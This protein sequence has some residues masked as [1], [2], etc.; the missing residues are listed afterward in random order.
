M[1]D[2]NA[3][4]QKLSALTATDDMFGEGARVISQG[5]VPSTMSA[6]LKAIDETLLE[7]TLVFIAGDA[8]VSI[9][10]SGR[11][12][13]GISAVAPNAANADKVIGKAL[14]RDAPAL[15]DEAF[16][17]FD[18]VLGDAN[19]VLMR[20]QQAEP[21][22]ESGER[23]ISA[24]GLAELWQIDLDEAP[25]PPMQ[26]FIRI[27]ESA[28][29]AMLHVSAGKIIA[30]QGDIHALQSIWDTQVTAFMSSQG[31]LPGRD[32]GPQL[33]C[34]EGA[35]ENGGAAALALAGEDV[36]LLVY[37]PAQL[38]AMHNAWQAIF[39]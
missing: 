27:N 35:L 31:K 30:N 39:D 9:V 18:T 13:R 8:S 21:F 10:A 5:G 36:A 32:D 14:S 7:R 20:S 16:A 37:D 34:L 25:L 23:G 11:R 28:V 12:L 26:R 3:L 15:L 19:K 33:I 17:V 2:L 29:S 6:A 1:S 24:T 38:G 4:A 22:G